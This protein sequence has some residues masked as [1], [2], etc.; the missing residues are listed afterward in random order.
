MAVRPASDPM[1]TILPAPAFRMPGSTAFTMRTV[2]K[3]LVSNWA[4]ASARLVSSAAPVSAYPALLTS[5]SSRP[6]CDRTWSTQARTDSSERTSSANSR[7]CSGVARS[8]RRAVPYTVNPRSVSS[9]AVARPIP[10]DAPVINTVCVMT[11]LPTLRWS[12]SA[13]A[14]RQ[15]DDRN[16]M[17]RAQGHS[18]RQM[19]E[20]RALKVSALAQ[21]GPRSIPRRRDGGSRSLPRIVTS[22]ATNPRCAGMIFWSATRTENHSARSTSG[23]CCCLPDFGGHSRENRLL[24]SCA[25]SQSPSTAQAWTTFFAQ[26]GPPGCTSSTS[27]SPFLRRNIRRPA[28]VFAIFPLRSYFCHTA[29][30]SVRSSRANAHSMRCASAYG[31]LEHCGI[32]LDHVDVVSRDLLRHA[33]QSSSGR[34]RSRYFDGGCKLHV[35]EAAHDEGTSRRVQR[36]RDRDPDY[37]HGAGAQGAARHGLGRAAATRAGVPDI[38]AELRHGRSEERRVGK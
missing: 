27:G 38:R 25:G 23:N 10:D 32:E 13:A 5:T 12:R 33:H 28:L 36:R 1:L 30:P 26:N 9:C 24:C 20:T 34:P 2:P 6:V 17:S 11:F 35:K 37:D 3:K 22:S 18:Q 16:A 21:A 4:L 19:P 15:Y 8:G 29:Y 31:K 7:N 14:P